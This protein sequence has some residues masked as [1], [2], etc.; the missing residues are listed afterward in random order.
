MGALL[1]RPPGPRRHRP[2]RHR[3][4]VAGAPVRRGGR[5][6]DRAPRR[7]RDRLRRRLPAGLLAADRRRRR[8]ALRLARRWRPGSSPRACGAA[9]GRRRRSDPGRDRPGRARLLLRGRRGGPCAVRALRRAAAR[10]QPRSRGGRDAR[11]SRGGC[12]DRARHRH[13]QHVLV[14]AVL[15]APPRPRRDRPPGGG[16]VARLITGL[17]AVKIRA[18]LERI[19][20]RAR[21]G[22]AACGSWP[23]S[24]TSRSRSCR[25]SPRPA[26][27]ARREPRAGPRGQGDRAPAVPLALHRPAPVAQG[28]ADRPVCGADPL[29]RH[30]TPRCAGWRARTTPILLEVN[31][32]GEESKAGHPAVGAAAVPGAL[33]GPGQRPDDDAAL[34]RRPGGQPPL[35]RRACASSPPSTTCASSRWAPRRTTRSRPRRARRSC[36]SARSCTRKLCG[37]RETPARRE[38]LPDHGPERH[39]AQ[40]RRLLRPRRRPRPLRGRAERRA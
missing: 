20:S 7:R 34:R 9:R 21:C 39:A 25:R 33:A 4:A 13:V 12:R 2:P 15:L 22:R 32:A 29:R 40:S 3:A 27:A 37:C 35:F 30:A 14:R 28:Q 23:R 38:R 1:L 36:A 18:N 10:A 11:S 26:Y 6:G 19:R 31:V 8:A 16:R 24:S 5:P 17:D